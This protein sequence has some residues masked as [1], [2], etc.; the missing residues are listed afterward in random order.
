MVQI[1]FCNFFKFVNNPGKEILPNGFHS[2]DLNRSDINGF[3]VSGMPEQCGIHGHLHKLRQP[4][5]PEHMVF[6]R[7]KE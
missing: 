7:R 5:Y 2:P 4:A 6:Q 1:F 3:T